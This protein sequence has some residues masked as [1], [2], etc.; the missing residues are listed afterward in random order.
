MQSKFQCKQTADWL[1]DSC[2]TKAVKKDK[3]GV[4]VGRERSNQV[5]SCAP[6][7]GH[8]REG[9]LHGFRGLPQEMSS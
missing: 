2:T 5:K 3:H 9:G 8:I 1:N 7:R 4:K 6:S